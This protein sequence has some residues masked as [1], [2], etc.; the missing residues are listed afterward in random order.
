MP[1]QPPEMISQQ[2][3]Q[4]PSIDEVRDLEEPQLETKC[5][6]EHDPI[7][8]VHLREQNTSTIKKVATHRQHPSP[9]AG[10]SENPETLSKAEASEE[11]N[12]EKHDEDVESERESEQARKIFLGGLSLE[13]TVETVETHFSVYGELEDVKVPLHRTL[14]GKSRGFGFVTFKKA[15]VANEVVQMVHKLCGR[16]VDVKFAVSRS[17][18]SVN[19]ASG[20]TQASSENN[21]I[22][23]AVS[24]TEDDT[25]V[26][27]PAI[28]SSKDITNNLETLNSQSKE[29]FYEPEM[30]DQQT[31]ILRPNQTPSKSRTS[32][33]GSVFG[34][35]STQGQSP[36]LQ[37]T[38]SSLAAAHTPK[39][40]MASHEQFS[41]S[42]AS[43]VST[44]SSATLS[45]ASQFSVRSF[46]AHSSEELNCKI[47]VG[48]LAA[49]V[50]QSVLR[51]YFSQ[52]GPIQHATVMIDRETNRSRGF[53]FVS[54]DD[55]P[56]MRRALSVDV[57]TISGKTAEVKQAIPRE[58]IEQHHLQ[59]QHHQQP[60][61]HQRHH[62]GPIYITT[63][64]LPG[65]PAQG[66]AISG[67]M[68]GY[69]VPGAIYY[70][71]S[72]PHAIGGMQY[73]PMSTTQV[74]QIV[75]TPV[76]QTSPSQEV[77]ED[78]CKPLK[79]NRQSSESIEQSTGASSGSTASSTSTNS[80]HHHQQLRSSS[81]HRTRQHQQPRI[82]SPEFTS[83]VQQL[84]PTHAVPMVP[85][86][87][88]P[89]HHQQASHPHSTTH[90]YVYPQ[91]PH[92]AHFHV[93]QAG[94]FY[95]PSYPYAH[96]EYAF[97]YVPGYQSLS[98]QQY[99]QMPAHGQTQLQELHVQHHQAPSDT[100]SPTSTKGKSDRCDGELKK[101]SFNTTDNALN[102]QASKP[103]RA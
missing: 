8:E 47:F 12:L 99:V 5:D 101:Q 46:G 95:G 6:I 28:A 102:K 41:C 40:Q 22:E 65:L 34:P 55:E 58:M 76:S 87:L 94:Y 23:C 83:T 52:F 53:G 97:G 59:Q 15:S 93:P 75:S 89:T 84:S 86:V 37:S 90:H 29:S 60:H 19:S 14:A 44:A 74:H 80:R 20:Q 35:T 32:T 24:T 7:S 96:S 18:N 56:S 103:S 42:S 63:Q 71:P 2:Q 62:S 49:S 61:Q 79:Q 25:H 13:A 68:Y 69:G 64:Q 26:T 21:H 67:E 66:V 9:T 81:Q 92:Q 36:L 54:F 51:S 31:K 100:S 73:H 48:G 3:Q 16:E 43:T 33:K 88:S 45:N 72:H 85:T 91:Q 57:H 38:K 30:A 27:K 39:T 70:F 1:P 78:H 50:T 82:D 17:H 77:A 98:P 11:G 10:P 4:Q